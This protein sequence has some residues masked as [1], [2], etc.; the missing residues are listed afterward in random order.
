MKKGAG[1]KNYSRNI[2]MAVLAVIIVT[3]LIYVSLPLSDKE[4]NLEGELASLSGAAL[5]GWTYCSDTDRCPA[6]E[7]DCDID[8]DCL[9]GYCAQDVGANYGQSSSM[10]VCECPSGTNWDGNACITET[11]CEENNPVAYW[12]FDNTFENV[13]NSPTSIGYGGPKFVEGKVGQAMQLDGKDDHIYFKQGSTLLGTLHTISFWIDYT[14][15]GGYGVVLGG[16][17]DPWTANSGSDY[18][19]YLTDTQLCYENGY[20]QNKKSKGES[21]VCVKHGGISGWHYVDVVRDG[22]SV[23]FYKD[24]VKIGSGTLSANNELQIGAIGREQRGYYLKGSLDELKIWDY[25][26]SEDEIKNEYE[27]KSSEDDCGDGEDGS[28]SCTTLVE[29]INT[30]LNANNGQQKCGDAYYTPALDVDD[31]G[32]IVSQDS[33]LVINQMNAG[34]YAFCDEVLNDGDDPCASSSCTD[35]DGG[36]NYEVKGYVEFPNDPTFGDNGRKYDVCKTFA[37]GEYVTEY[38]CING[39]YEGDEN[40]KCPNSCKDGACVSQ[41]AQPDYIISNL[42]FKEYKNLSGGNN[43]LVNVTSVVKNI[44]NA[45]AINS[46]TTKAINHY[47]T[48]ALAINQS[49]SYTYDTYPCNKPFNVTVTADFYNTIAESNEGNNIKTVFIDCVI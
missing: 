25:A 28:A 49:H 20:V 43:T 42:T 44:G 41:T 37:D 35:S 18:G 23:I 15:K 26:L 21:V 17:K 27:G 1:N 12:K 29:D 8:S 46:S 33:L 47:S 31:D 38:V 7:G 22:T 40:Y 48:P 10:D 19:V 36:K 3:L 24:G 32:Y 5:W 14:K 45:A 39:I 11:G 4:N 16:M 2:L 13:Y 34:N 6:G 30:L 9:T